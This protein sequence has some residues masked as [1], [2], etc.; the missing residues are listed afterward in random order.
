MNRDKISTLNIQ[1]SPV[2]YKKDKILSSGLEHLKAIDY[3][4]PF[5]FFKITFFNL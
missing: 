1:Q 2:I 4:L 5:Y 3:N